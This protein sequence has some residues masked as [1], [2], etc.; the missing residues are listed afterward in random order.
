M[1]PTLPRGRARK[2]QRRGG[3]AK[4]SRVG[5]EEATEGGAWGVSPKRTQVP[6]PPSL[7]LL[8]DDLGQ[9][10]LGRRRR[11]HPSQAWGR[12]GTGHAAGI[13]VRLLGAAGLGVLAHGCGQHHVRRDRPW[14]AAGE[15]ARGAAP[16]HGRSLAGV[17][18]PSPLV[19]PGSTGRRRDGRGGGSPGGAASASSRGSRSPGRATQRWGPGGVSQPAGDARRPGGQG[20]SA[21]SSWA[22]RSPPATRAP[23]GSPGRRSAAQ[24]HRVS[25]ETHGSP[26]PDA[27]L[28]PLPL[29]GGLRTVP[30]DE[31]SGL[32]RSCQARRTE[33]APGV[34]AHR[35]REVRG[36]WH[37]PAIGAQPAPLVAEGP[38]PAGGRAQN[39]LRS[40]RL[41]TP[42]L[43]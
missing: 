4:F 42:G 12:R 34:C 30:G 31:A 39:S 6:A 32:A 1:T 19:L 27:E 13:S 35:Q 14:L 9:A 28:S 38:E 40:V 2:L 16:G 11:L 10:G 7:L 22:L 25:G 26:P 17:P 43:R 20:I 37:L 29:A 36:P 24:L 18:V 23:S 33:C 41:V 15:R 5:R 8:L 21:R 3:R